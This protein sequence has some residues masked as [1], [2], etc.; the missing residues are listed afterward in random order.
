M[1]YFDNAATTR[2]KPV[3]V[4]WRLLKE[5]IL[6][7]NPGRSAHKAAVRT[8]LK[9]E[10]TRDIIRRS[11]FE[12]DVIFT[13]NCTE[14]L[15]LAV[16][17][18]SAPQKVITTIT[19]HNSVLRPL[20]RLELQKKIRLQV[21][22]PNIE[23]FEKHINKDTGMVVMG[24][25]SNV[26]GQRNDIE[27]IFRMAKERSKAITVLDGAQS[28]G[29]IT[30]DYADVDM[31]ASSGH[32]GLYG[33]QGTGFLLVRNGIRLHPLFVG[34]TGSS[35]FEIDIPEN[36]P[37]GMEAGTCNAPGIIALGDGI[38]YVLKNRERI[39]NK[40]K[41]L[42]ERLVHLLQGEKSVEI[43]SAQNGIVLLN[44]KG[45]SCGEVA[46]FLSEKYGI[47]VRSGL[48]CAPL[49]HKY[50]GTAPEGAVRIS[51]GRGNYLWQINVL[52]HALKEISQS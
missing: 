49:M 10:E 11:F 18:L 36:I 15:N 7:S 23:S 2:H 40:E 25:V 31:L 42:S 34:G 13:K 52:S 45:K 12:G 30:I 16:T 38:K 6:G 27:K 28:T 47:C 35:G 50:L 22:E 21:I 46:D 17:A 4:Y 29:K 39:M 51:F 1:I 5:T 20:K 14:A 43:Y 33:V 37:E 19:E 9:I 44:V 24:A 8:A 48:H 41:K 3:C 32:K 26:T